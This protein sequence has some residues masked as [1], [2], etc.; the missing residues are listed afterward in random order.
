MWACENL[1]L[2]QQLFS[3]RQ[4]RSSN[5][6][7]KSKTLVIKQRPETGM[8]IQEHFQN[9]LCN[10][11]HHWPHRSCV[12]LASHTDIAHLFLIRF[13]G[14]C[15]GGGAVEGCAKGGSFGLIGTATVLGA[16]TYICG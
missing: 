11:L 7:R 8:C 1:A 4:T 14:F 13:S 6:S 10:P 15:V 2:D 9:T 3:E 5:K 16:C 12:Q